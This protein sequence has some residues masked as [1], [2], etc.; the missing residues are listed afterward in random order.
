MKKHTVKFIAL[1]L[2]LSSFSLRGQDVKKTIATE[3]TIS[4][5]KTSVKIITSSDANFKRI[6]ADFAEK[7]TRYMV[8]YKTDRKGRYREYVVYFKT[9]DKAEVVN[10]IAHY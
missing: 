8:T 9:E 10:K 1:A 5:M 3:T 4:D 6:L 7:V 2:C